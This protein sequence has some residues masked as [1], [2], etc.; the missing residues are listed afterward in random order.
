[1]WDQNS[2]DKLSLIWYIYT[3]RSYKCT[4]SH[5]FTSEKANPN[6]LLQLDVNLISPL[7]LSL[8]SLIIIGP[9]KRKGEK[10]CYEV[11]FH[12]IIRHSKH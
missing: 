4:C 1:M 10:G 12:I 2:R 8:D 9:T 11:D 5:V 6:T 7:S 3:D